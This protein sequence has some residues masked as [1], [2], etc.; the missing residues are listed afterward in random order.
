MTS[1]VVLD[2][3]VLIEHLRATDKSKTFYYNLS[4]QYEEKSFSM[5][6]Q[7][8]VSVGNHQ[9]F[10]EIWNRILANSTIFPLTESIVELAVLIYKDLKKRNMLIEAFDILI[11]ATTLANDLPL[12]TLNRKH[13][14]RIGSLKLVDDKRSMT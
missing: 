8:E 5:I 6:V 14:E 3:S 2:S 7:F 1:T 10:D 4:L 12:A 9:R 13:F 11:A